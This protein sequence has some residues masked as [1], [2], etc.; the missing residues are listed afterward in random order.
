[1]LGKRIFTNRKDQK[2]LLYHKSYSKV[3]LQKSVNTKSRIMRNSTVK[4]GK[5]KERKK[6]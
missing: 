4:I 2:R 6:K 5:L 1:M 3:T